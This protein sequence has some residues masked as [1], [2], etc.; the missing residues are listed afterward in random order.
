M[1]RNIIDRYWSA[2]W[3]FYSDR[4]MSALCKCS[5]PEILFTCLLA[6]LFPKWNSCKAAEYFLYFYHIFYYLVFVNILHFYFYPFLL[7]YLYFYLYY[8]L[9]ILFIYLFLFP[10]SFICFYI[11]SK[12]KNKKNNI[13]KHELYEKE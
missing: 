13:I 10:I 8:F 7:F 1:I 12:S 2:C 11:K 3:S 6:G 9:F 4:L 5:N